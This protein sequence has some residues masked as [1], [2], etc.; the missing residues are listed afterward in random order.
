MLIPHVT[1][2]SKR[3]SMNY[4]TAGAAADE[5]HSAR[6]SL[7][8]SVQNWQ[9]SSSD[10]SYVTAGK[11]YQLA[12]ICLLHIISSDQSLASWLSLLPDLLNKLPVGSR[13]TTTLGWPLSVLGSLARG[14]PCK[15]LQ[16][17]EHC[18]A[19]GVDYLLYFLNRSGPPCIILQQ[20]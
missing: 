3:V 13:V 6:E 5:I 1:A 2:I 4:E 10:P 16:R 7:L 14:D 12:L 15:N 8:L 20:H 17:I 18:R 19:L 11:I 9:P